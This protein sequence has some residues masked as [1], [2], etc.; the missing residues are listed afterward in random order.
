MDQISKPRS[1]GPGRLSNAI[2]ALLFAIIGLMLFGFASTELTF[3]WQVANATFAIIVALALFRRPTRLLSIFLMALSVAFSSRYLYWRFTETLPIGEG[4]SILD[5]PLAIGLLMAEL[6]AYT[7]LFL[8]YFQVLWPLHRKPAA[9]PEDDAL[10]PN[11]DI[12][13]PTYNEP[14]SVVRP[15][16]LAALEMD[17]P[18]DKMKV[19]VLDDGRRP[20]FAAFAELVGATHLTRSDN[21]HAKAGNI[22]RAMEKTQGEFVAIFDCDH[23]PTRSFLQM[24]VGTLLA[25][26][27]NALVQTPHHFF[28]PDPFER[29]LDTFRKVPNEGELF[30]GLLQDGNDF[31]DATFFCGSCAVIRRTALD[32]IGGIAVETVTEDAHTALRLHQRGWHSAYI[33]VPQAAGLAT[34]SLSA[35]IGQRIRW[36]RGMAQIFRVDNPLI[37]PGLSLGQRL[38]YCNAMMHFFYGLPRLVFLTSPMAFLLV[39]AEI[40]QAEALMILAYAMPHLVLSVVANSRLQGR[41]RHS[42]WAEVYETVLAIFIIL[43]TTLALINPKLGK[44]NVTAKGGIVERDYFDGDIAKPYYVLYIINLLGIVAGVGRIVFGDS[45][46]LSTVILNMVWATYNLVVLGAA[47]SVAGE[48]KQTRRAVRVAEQLPVLVRKLGERQTVTATTQDLSTNGIALRAAEA[49]SLAIGDGV[50]VSIESPGRRVWLP[51]AVRRMDTG[52]VAVELGQLDLKQEANLTQALFGRAD[53]WV[54]WRDL[55]VRDR[56]LKSLAQ[57]FRISLSGSRKFWQWVG[58]QTLSLFRGKPEPAKAAG[59]VS[60]SAVLLLIAFLAATGLSP[61]AVAQDPA[62]VPAALPPPVPAAPVLVAVRSAPLPVAAVAPVPAPPE[63]PPPP[64]TT[65]RVTE[66]TRRVISLQDLGAQYPMRLVTVYG[67]ASAGLPLRRD[68]VVTRARLRLRYSHS[69]SL[70]E[71]ISH[72]TVLVNDEVVS[73]FNLDLDTASGTE[74]L[75]EI[76][77]SLV[78]EFNQIRFDMAMH[79]T[80]SPD[81][82]EDPTHSSLWGV[83]SNQSQLELNLA[84]LSLPPDLALLPRPFLEPNDQRRLTLPFTLATDAKRDALSAAGVVAS[85]FGAQADYRGAEFP[86]LLS[87]LPPG[88]GVVLRIGNAFAGELGPAP[89]WARIRV[90]PNPRNPAARLL[91]IEASDEAGLL[92]AAQALVMGAISL[93]G[94]VAQVQQLDLP[95]PAARGVAPRWIDPS[96]RTRLADISQGATSVRGL[97][98]GPMGFDFRLPPDV[99]FLDEVGA[100]VD[101]RYRYAPIT[102]PGSTL[103][104]LFN[105][106]FVGSVILPRAGEPP[107]REAEEVND[108]V[109]IEIPAFRLGSR[110]QLT[111]QYQFRRAVSKPCEHFVS[112]ALGGSV[113]PDSEV[114]FGRHGRYARWPDLTRFRD[115]GLPFS[116]SADLGE[117]AFLL[118]HDADED[119]LSAA[120]MLAGH[121]G[122]TTGAPGLRLAIDSIANAMTYS[123][124]DLILIGRADQLKLPEDWIERL[125]LLISKEGARLTETS[126]AAS[127]RAWIAQRDLVGAKQFAGRVLATGG[128]ELGVLIGAR[129]PFGDRSAVWVTA[130]DR[131]PLVGVTETLIDSSRRQF[132]EGD[133]SL[134]HGKEVTGYLLGDQWGTGH[135]AWYHAIREWLAQRP[136]LMAPLALGIAFLTVV[137]LFAR[138][139]RRAVLRLKTGNAK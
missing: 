47:M 28:S 64:L 20:E 127:F 114:E 91:L 86:V 51:A 94:E 79:Y 44:F 111:L 3:W 12:F 58:R 128:R 71:R 6:Y 48:R 137:L 26:P 72:L 120:L 37:A 95:P 104:T 27:R 83:I 70:I 42:W 135:L 52:V 68:Q 41:F 88:H 132:I 18:Q 113:D 84:N 81:E 103:S 115:G 110:N 21:K 107:S 133:V 93:E 108:Q 77:P 121:L 82:C 15:T 67:Q 10:W 131:A 32:E 90:V 97:N 34:E 16:I 53:A 13:I 74:R 116:L 125:P 14:L 30:Y 98:P 4:H 99:Y 63:P 25:D 55:S 38:C 101:L 109:D 45:E 35:H 130:G 138:L 66:E 57:V 134:V 54:D 85:W 80:N 29:N 7:I 123:D 73:T 11:V 60:A 17:W 2:F 40:I 1:E 9:L 39:G 92:R 43:P 59:A 78:Q 126:R 96:R 75:I 50:E 129:S 65:D 87:A 22:N 56:P 61:E 31:W 19:Y 112:D 139:R 100:T 105:D 106:A 102:A 118:P 5:L 117:T 24:T 36:A 119:A 124:R 8:G 62:A 49:L 89:D 46:K 76:N 136:Y 33:S 122:Q 69:P 23:I